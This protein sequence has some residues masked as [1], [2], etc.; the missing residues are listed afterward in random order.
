M[1][2]LQMLPLHTKV[3]WNGRSDG[4]ALFNTRR[5]SSRVRLRH[6]PGGLSDLDGTVCP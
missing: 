5:P 1:G 2:D 6:G 3:T 4:M